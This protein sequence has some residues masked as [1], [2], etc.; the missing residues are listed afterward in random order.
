MQPQVT[1]P[2]SAGQSATIEFLQWQ[3]RFKYFGNDPTIEVSQLE[4]DEFDN[5]TW[6]QR[7]D[8]TRHNYKIGAI[9]DRVRLILGPSP[10]ERDILITIK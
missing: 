10:L 2:F 6:R 4:I 7:D 9:L 5:P 1:F 3:T 8:F